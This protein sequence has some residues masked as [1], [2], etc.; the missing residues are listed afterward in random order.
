MLTRKTPETL[1]TRLKIEGQG[2]TIQMDVTYFNRSQE[3]IEEVLAKF[4]ASD[5]AQ[6]DVGYANRQTLLFVLKEMESEY[7]HTDEG[8]KELERDRPGM[9]ELLFFGFHRARRMDLAKN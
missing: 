8:L 2:E 1:A 4:Q 6:E 9:I 7:P 3:Q 5:K